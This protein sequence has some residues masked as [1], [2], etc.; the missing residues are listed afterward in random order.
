MDY[1][2]LLRIFIS[3]QLI[4][5]SSCTTTT[6]LGPKV[7]VMPAPGKPFSQF[8]IEEQECRQYAQQSIN[9]APKEAS[10]NAVGTAV[11]GTALGTVAGAIMGGKKG[12]GVGAGVGLIGGSVAGAGEKKSEAR[13]IQW[14][15][16]IAYSQCMYAKGNQVPGYQTQQPKS[17]FTK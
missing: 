2:W 4:F 1:A 6:P 3:L 12:A 13:D 5:I 7:A 16:D 10:K 11:A 9:N 8:V 15:Y 14:S 17:E